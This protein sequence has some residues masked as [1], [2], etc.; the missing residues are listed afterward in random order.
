MEFNDEIRVIQLENG[1]WQAKQYSESSESFVW[2]G[3]VRENPSKAFKDAIDCVLPKQ[4][5][6]SGE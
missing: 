4:P 5:E 1:R 6:K 3:F 2:K